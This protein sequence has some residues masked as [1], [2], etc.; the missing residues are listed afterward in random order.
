MNSN[1]TLKTQN[2]I[3]PWEKIS[4]PIDSPSIITN[5]HFPEERTT[6]I[7]KSNKSCFQYQSSLIHKTIVLKL[8]YANVHNW[9]DQSWKQKLQTCATIFSGIFRS[10]YLFL[11][12]L[13]LFF[14]YSIVHYFSLSITCLFEQ[15]NNC[16]SP[17]THWTC[18]FSLTIHMYSWVVKDTQRTEA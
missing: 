8:V 9:L 14:I 17:S 3:C 10:D 15:K 6:Q 12:F 4:F 7:S 5:C 2:E 16:Y 11:L 13:N 1:D 18:T